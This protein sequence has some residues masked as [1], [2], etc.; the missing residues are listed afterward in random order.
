MTIRF[1]KIEDTQ[2]EYI[3]DNWWKELSSQW[4]QRIL[5]FTINYMK[6]H[7]RDLLRM[8][9]IDLTSDNRQN[10]WFYRKY[11]YKVINKTTYFNCRNVDL[12]TLEPLRYCNNLRYL[13]CFNINLNSLNGINNLINI[14]KLN[15]SNNKLITLKDISKLINLKELYC[16]DNNI[17]SL[18]GLENCYKLESLDCSMTNIN[19]FK[20][21]NVAY[22][23]RS[24]I[25]NDSLL[26]D[27]HF[28]S[29]LKCRFNKLE[30]INNIDINTLLC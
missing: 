28:I 26:L 17:S 21:L 23:L 8:R 5:D 13:N 24:L 22:N 12:K 9:G 30:Y 3:N 20:P 19:S 11:I 2:Y 14:E 7:H 6:T 18:E 4:R 1:F 27:R 29:K 10:Y 25:I 15:C 16:S